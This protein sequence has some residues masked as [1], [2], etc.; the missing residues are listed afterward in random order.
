MDLSRYGDIILNMSLLAL[1]FSL[2]SG[3]IVYSLGALLFACIFC[4][5]FDR[6]RA[7]WGVCAF[8]Y[9]SNQVDRVTIRL[10]ALPTAVLAANVVFQLRIMRYFEMENGKTIL[11]C[12]IVFCAHFAIHEICTLIIFSCFPDRSDEEDE[13][14][15]YF[16]VEQKTEHNIFN[17]NKV[18]QLRTQHLQAA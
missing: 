14:P 17:S 4:Y 6:W 13:D 10:L 3:W 1:V 7:N 15:D 5:V 11:L 8:N 18:H 2:A 16:D 12:G 9:S